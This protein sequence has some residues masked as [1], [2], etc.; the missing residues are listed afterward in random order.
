MSITLPLDRMSR[1]DKIRAME[2]LW[3]DLTRDDAEIDSPA[4]HVEALRETEQRVQQGKAK[5]SDW[6]EA[7]RRILRKAAKI[8]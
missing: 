2:A 7:K 5:F 4:W 1:D 8:R 6:P 3:A